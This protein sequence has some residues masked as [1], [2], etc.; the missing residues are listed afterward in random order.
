MSWLVKCQNLIIW[1]DSVNLLTSGFGYGTVILSNTKEQNKCCMKVFSPNKGWFNCF[2]KRTS[3]QSIRIQ[4]KS[5]STNTGSQKL[6]SRND[7]SHPQN[8]LW[9]K[10]SSLAEFTYPAIGVITLSF[11]TGKAIKDTPGQWWQYVFS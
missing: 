3:K 10:F 11:I 1:S 5:I 9:P 7:R 2:R 8:K 4:V 6:Y